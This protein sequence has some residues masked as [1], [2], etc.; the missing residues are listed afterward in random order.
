MKKGLNILTFL[1]VE[2]LFS[3]MKWE[4]NKKDTKITSLFNRFC[5]RLKLLTPEQQ[6]FVIELSR[7]LELVSL[8][9]YIEKFLMS[10]FDVPLDIFDKAENIFLCP[11]IEPYTDI[12]EETTR[13][14]KSPT[15]SSN[16]LLFWLERSDLTWI[17]NFHKFKFEEDLDKVKKEF[18]PDNSVIILIDDFIGTGETAI[19]ACK[20]ILNEDFNGIELNSEKLIIVTLIAQKEGKQKIEDEVNVKVYSDIIKDKGISDSF[21]KSIVSDK[22]DLMKSIEKRVCNNKR[23][24]KKYSFGYGETE[25]LVSLLNKTP[26]NTFPVYWYETEVK[27]APL[28]RFKNFKHG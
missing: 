27:I 11:L 10:L 18:N 8:K 9:D 22:I 17:D 3:I 21:V 28:P 2:R 24:L 12:E 5:E 1:E 26:N 25:A 20:M 6:S 14:S 4:L 7:K 23:F 15:K 13:V 19:N 16:F